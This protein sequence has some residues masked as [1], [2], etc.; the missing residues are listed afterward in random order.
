MF[1]DKYF[2]LI[3]G[4]DIKEELNNPKIEEINNFL[5]DIYNLRQ[6]G[7]QQEGEY[8]I[9]NLVFKEFRNMGY[10]DN[11]KQLKNDLIGKDLSLE[12]LNQ[13]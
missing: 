4:K 12:G 2:M 8:S 13:C 3:D 5:E 9:G 7:L 6:Q 10:L 1:E 11:L